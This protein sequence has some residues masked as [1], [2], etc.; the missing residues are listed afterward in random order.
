M[1]YRLADTWA[2]WGHT[3]VVIKSNSALLL[4]LLVLIS[5]SFTA[6]STA[7]VGIRS[8]TR[9]ILDLFKRNP[10]PAKVETKK[11]KKQ[12][13]SSRVTVQSWKKDAVASSSPPK[14]QHQSF[15]EE[16]KDSE[17]VH[18]PMETERREK[19]KEEEERG[20]SFQV[21]A[22]MNQLPHISV[23]EVEEKDS[24]EDEFALRKG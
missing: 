11:D 19:E 9:S 24:E 8:R 7:D 2:Y 14:E 6:S 17:D 15:D 13:K 22:P 16:L 20:D 21:A 1:C 5:L 3:H 10:S 18:D 4:H 23:D 12:S